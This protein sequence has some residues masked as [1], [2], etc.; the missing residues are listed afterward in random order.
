[1]LELIS[2]V[3]PLQIRIEFP[4][5]PRAGEYYDVTLS[6]CDN[7][8]CTCTR[9]SLSLFR[10]YAAGREA[11]GEEFH[12]PVDVEEKALYG[13]P[14]D[15]ASYDRNMAQSFVEQ[16]TVDDWVLL[17]GLYQGYK[18]KITELT[19]DAELDTRFPVA[20]IEASSLLVG[21]NEILPFSDDLRLELD[22]RHLLLADQYCLRPGCDCTESVFTVIDLDLSAQEAGKK[23]YLALRFDYRNGLWY[24]ESRGGED[25][26]LAGRVAEKVLAEE[27]RAWLEGR[28]NRLKSLYRLYKREHH[29]PKRLTKGKIGR[30][31]PCPCG[32]G[33][34]YKK[35][36]L[37]SS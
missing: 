3:T 5:G 26:A 19:P 13:A 18:R 11:S 6:F 9:A 34:K 1:M 14:E 8:I 24:V 29:Q 28:H 17:Q 27:N 20:E 4:D 12:F 2:N 32:S 23:G 37:I 36:C 22:G 16:L 15:I 25:R 33:K 7:P 30:N 21:F 35:C 10:D 31:D